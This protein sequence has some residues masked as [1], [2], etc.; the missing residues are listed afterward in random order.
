M[1]QAHTTRA[2]LMTE[3]VDIMERFDF[4]A[5]Q[6]AMTALKWTWGQ[7][8]TPT[9]QELKDQAQRLMDGAVTGWINMSAE[10]RKYGCSWATGGFE[11]RVEA[12]SNNTARLSLLFYVTR[13]CGVH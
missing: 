6:T 2:E 3:A 5:V 11:A 1:S 13:T 7:G 4:A 10:S 8:R 9:I 12:Y